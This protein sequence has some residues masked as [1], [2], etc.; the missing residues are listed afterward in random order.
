MSPATLL[1]YNTCVK[2]VRDV[3]V[4]F[5]YCYPSTYR[6][7]MTGLA[8]HLFYSILN[9]REDTSCERYFRFDALSASK[10]VDSGRPLKDNHILGFSL[11]YEED[12]L[13]AI[14]MLDLG[15]VPVIAAERAN[16]DPLVIF[17]GPAASAN[18]EPYVDFTDAFVIGEGDLVIHEIIEA[19]RN[20]SSRNSALSLLGEIDG[21]YV[22][23]LIPTQV[24]RLVVDDLDSL[25]HPTSQIIPDVPEGSPLEPVFGKS[26]LVEV[27]RGCGHSCGF[28]LVGHVCRPRRVRSLEVLQKIIERGVSDTPIRRVSLIA[29]SLGDKD[30]LEDL[31][32]WIV[33]QDLGLSVPSLRA[34][35]VTENLLKSLVTSGQRT[36]TIA[37]ETGSQELR[38]MIGK[39][40]DDS[41]IENAV[42]LAAETGY[43]A[44]KLYFIIGLPKETDEHVE[45]IVR[46]VKRLADLSGLRITASVNPYIPKAHTRWE[47][48]AQPPIDS[49]RKKLR[50]I[51]AGLRNVPKVRLEHLDLRNSRIQAALSVGDRSL[52]RVIRLAS[53]YGGLSG[54]RR[55][56]KETGIPLF[57]VASDS[58]RLK[59][60]LPWSFIRI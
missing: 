11:T 14:Q 52:G 30:R 15:A 21:V 47:R 36:L 13:N 4:L 51:K 35:S 48:E 60:D 9:S 44:V 20:S 10:S 43:K 40:L 55:G 1:E 31:A 50:I 6:A 24:D 16:D 46:M 56:E 29:S 2:D 39:G 18:P 28:C 42:S 34:D 25:H 45:S 22:P 3:D 57:S 7:G 54:W 5:G 26:L 19:V 53:E 33:G 12:V 27:A 38:K 23:S 8:T 32:D 49:L 59:G 58:E 17:G 41:A 37:P